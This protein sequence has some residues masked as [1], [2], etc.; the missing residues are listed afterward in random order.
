MCVVNQER[1][2]G[3]VAMAVFLKYARAFGAKYQVLLAA[4]LFLAAQ[5]AQ[6]A[7]DWWLSV[8]EPLALLQ[9]LDARV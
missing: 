4:M 7:N 1:D 9:R 6:E 8:S 5:G 2:K 3:A